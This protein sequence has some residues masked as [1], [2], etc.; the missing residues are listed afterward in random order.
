MQCYDALADT[1]DKGIGYEVISLADKTVAKLD[2]KDQAL[3]GKGWRPFVEPTRIDCKY[4][5]WQAAEDLLF[6]RIV[7]PYLFVRESTVALKL[8]GKAAMAPLN[9]AV[10]AGVGCYV[11]QVEEE[12][13]EF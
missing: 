2:L 13:Q 4:G 6:P 9:V 8:L 11:G 3:M 1:V 5:S 10:G 7:C 12:F